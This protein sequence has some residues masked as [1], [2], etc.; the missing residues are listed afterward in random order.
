MLLA[1]L[2]KR[3]IALTLDSVKIMM[4]GYSVIGRCLLGEMRDVWN[5]IM[6]GK[7]IPCKLQ[8]LRQVNEKNE[9]PCAVL[10]TFS[11]WVF[12][13]FVVREIQREPSCQQKGK[14]FARGFPKPENSLEACVV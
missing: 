3:Q 10:I 4:C 13:F 8:K 14:F 5:W 9:G 11:F 6:S 7:K 2:A 12:V 1:R